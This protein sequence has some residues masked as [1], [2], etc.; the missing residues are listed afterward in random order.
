MV[1]F[2]TACLGLLLMHFFIWDAYVPQMGMS[3]GFFT[4]F[5][6]FW[7]HATFMFAL[8][9]LVVTLVFREPLD[10]H[11]LNL[12]ALH[13]CWGYYIGLTPLV[14]GVIYLA[15]GQRE[16]QATYPFYHSPE[17]WGLLLLWELLFGASM[18]CGEFFYRGFCVHGLK[19]RYGH[20]AV[21]V[22]TMAYFMIHMQKPLV[23]AAASI[24][25]GIALAVLS[26]RTGSIAGGAWL[27]CVIAWSIDMA[28][29]LRRGDVLR[30][31]PW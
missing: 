20:G 1:T 17:S 15:A 27:H 12:R 24:A 11:G 2:L 8:P 26:L 4:C 13:G 10:E 9:A 30:T 3:A 18:V 23:E 7:R 16:L 22:S 5:V 25:F 29:L 6:Y 21:W 14:F 28:V 19:H 31:L